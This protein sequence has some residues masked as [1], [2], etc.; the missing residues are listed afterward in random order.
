M[1][2]TTDSKIHNRL[3]SPN[4]A[5][6]TASKSGW[7][8]SRFRAAYLFFES[9]CFSQWI[10]FSGSQSFADLL[11]SNLISKNIIIMTSCLKCL[12]DRGAFGFG[13]CFCGWGVLLVSVMCFGCCQICSFRS[14]I[15]VLWLT[16]CLSIFA[17]FTWISSG[18]EFVSGKFDYFP[19][20]PTGGRILLPPCICKHRR[21]TGPIVTLGDLSRKINYEG[22][23]NFIEF[24]IRPR[25]TQFPNVTVSF[26]S[27]GLQTFANTCW[28]CWSTLID[29]FCYE[30]LWSP[31]C[32]PSVQLLPRPRLVFFA[33]SVF[34][35]TND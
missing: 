35:F 20:F 6:S 15:F 31:L 21:K 26:F 7:A 33:V 10:V 14:C 29:Y 4:T 9:G 3:G 22:S 24:E 16:A 32:A 25:K 17:F 12:F 19:F 27:I 30:P 18:P 5:R 13:I 8:R 2:K 28:K 34:C 1:R 11:Q 23:S